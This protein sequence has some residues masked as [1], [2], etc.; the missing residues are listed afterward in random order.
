MGQTAMTIAEGIYLL[1]STVKPQEGRE[2]PQD[3]PR[4]RDAH[5]TERDGE[6]VMAVY[7]RM[8]AGNRE[9]VEDGDQTGEERPCNACR[10]QTVLARHPLYIADEDD[11]FDHA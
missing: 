6:T 11:D 4:F 2:N 8:E 9:C 5:L 10:A 7:T 3:V 1:E